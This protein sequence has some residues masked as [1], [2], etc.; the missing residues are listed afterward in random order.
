MGAQAGRMAKES[1]LRAAMM[2]SSDSVPEHLDT[3]ICPGYQ[4]KL[5]DLN[6]MVT[7]LVPPLSEGNP[8]AIHLQ[9]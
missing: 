8:R 4:Q 5:A 1:Q 7:R 2:A 6:A 3:P 9:S